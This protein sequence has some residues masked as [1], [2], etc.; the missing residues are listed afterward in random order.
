[1]SGNIVRDPNRFYTGV[2]NQE[3]SYTPNR[4][5]S[6]SS[7]FAQSMYN[8][9]QSRPSFDVEADSMGLAEASKDPSWF[10]SNLG[11]I[12]T[13]FDI[14]Q[15]LASMYNANRAMNLAKDQFNTEKKYA[16][17]NLYNTAQGYRHNLDKKLA[18]DWAASNTIQ[19]R[20]DGDRDKYMS[21]QKAKYDVKDKV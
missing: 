13:G 11:N 15:G 12:K 9:D 7:R 10:S 1:M 17:A 14:A 18:S 20:Y 16:G 21:E 8:A 19:Q 3:T 5:G 4:Y 2:Y 6:D